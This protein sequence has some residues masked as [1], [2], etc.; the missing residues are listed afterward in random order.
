MARERAVKRAREGDAPPAGL[1]GGIVSVGAWRGHD[2]L[3]ASSSAAA[4]SRVAAAMAAGGSPFD[5]LPDELVTR[6]I[7]QASERSYVEA[8]LAQQPS[9]WQR[10]RIRP[11]SDEVVA[12]LLKQPKKRRK[13][14]RSLS[15]TDGELSKDSFI[16]MSKSFRQQLAEL[17]ISC[18]GAVSPG[19]LPSIQHFS[20]LEQVC[21]HGG[22]LD[23]LKANIAMVSGPFV[24]GAVQALASLPLQ[25]LTL[26]KLPMTLET[27]QAL[28][29]LANTLKRLQCGIIV[30]GTLL[31]IFSSIAAFQRL[32]QLGTEFYNNSGSLIWPNTS[33]A[34]L[35]P[36]SSLSLLRA[37][38]V[39][40]WH[41]HTGFLSG[42]RQ[43]EYV[44]LN[45]TEAADITTL[46]PLAGSL[47]A[48]ILV[49]HDLDEAGSASFA[50][51][52][53]K[54]AELRSLNVTLPTRTLSAI[55]QQ[56]TVQWTNLRTLALQSSGDAEIP[57]TFL[58]RLASDAPS[59]HM[60]T[61]ESPL[62]LTSAGGLVAVSSLKRLRRL[63]IKD[64][65]RAALG[66]DARDAL[67]AALLDVD[68]HYVESD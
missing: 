10:I 18:G 3:Q 63:V 56:P 28:A 55:A 29:P 34:D 5:A 12:A 32:E 1:G 11:A 43:L 58:K 39:L 53:S 6:I 33:E 37:Y 22:S 25:A 16:K 68:I 54:L 4:L 38:S 50:A 60:L 64:K 57:G 65:A 49:H 66:G 13:A 14:M 47:R 59:L 44:C 23:W 67:R 35:Q 26:E 40:V 19:V 46:L 45:M 36:L 61:V 8:G 9:L 42:M 21:I 7:G 62:P 31:P 48:A 2:Q 51:T 27:L 24:Q 15:L 41:M 52:A 17:Y 20:Q 30:N